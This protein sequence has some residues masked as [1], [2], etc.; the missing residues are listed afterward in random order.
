MDLLVLVFG[1]NLAVRVVNL[2][3]DV[4]WVFWFWMVC[5]DFGVFRLNLRVWID[6]RWLC[7]NLVLK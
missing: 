4:F 2:D 5:V 1:L 7:L 3:F 6:A